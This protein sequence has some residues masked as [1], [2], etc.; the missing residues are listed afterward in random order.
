MSS[1]ERR[2]QALEAGAGLDRAPVAVEVIEIPDGAATPLGVLAGYRVVDHDG[3]QVVMR[4]PDETEGALAD[5]A[6]AQARPQPRGHV[7]VLYEIRAQRGA[8]P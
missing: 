3:E 5:R 6:L 8:Q 7:V 1:I 4:R 2:V